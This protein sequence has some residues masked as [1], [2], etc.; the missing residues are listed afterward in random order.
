MEVLLLQDVPKIG[1]KNDLLL[2]GDGYALNFLL[3]QQKAIV[4]TPTV[5]K[6]YAE[7]I[8][9]RAEQKII[10]NKL[11]SGA[12]SALEG[13]KIT[14]ERKITKT[15]KLYAAITEKHIVEELMKQ[16]KIEV[17]QEMVEITDTIKELGTFDVFLRIGDQKQELKVVVKEEK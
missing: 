5:R 16:L 8:K 3:P 12:A 14:F 7:Q 15:G 10:E 9:R 13:K 4:A 6:R 11:Q 1:L 2:V 17:S